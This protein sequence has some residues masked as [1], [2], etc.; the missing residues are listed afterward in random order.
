MLPFRAVKAA[1]VYHQL[2]T[3]TVKTVFI[4]LVFNII[5]KIRLGPASPNVT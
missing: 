5:R 2:G 3:L 4:S 1:T